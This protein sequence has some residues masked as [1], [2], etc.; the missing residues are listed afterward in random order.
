MRTEDAVSNHST[1]A[2]STTL[3]VF[4][5]MY[6]AVFGA[7][8]SYMLKLAAK[9]PHEHE[10]GEIAHEVGQVQHPARPLSGAPDAVHT[11]RCADEQGD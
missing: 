7:G 11:P 1:L 10:D 6:A 8:V 9:G 5:F 2:L 4:I 3:I